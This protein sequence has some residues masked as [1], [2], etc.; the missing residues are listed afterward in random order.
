MLCSV[1]CEVAVQCAGVVPGKRPGSHT[2]LPAGSGSPLLAAHLDC[3]S[4][5]QCC[6]HKCQTYLLA[7]AASRGSSCHL[8]RRVSD[9]A[10]HPG[11][12][13]GCQCCLGNKHGRP[14]HRTPAGG[15]TSRPRQCSCSTHS[16]TRPGTI[17]VPWGTGLLPEW[18]PRKGRL[19]LHT[20]IPLVQQ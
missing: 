5:P 4:L 17:Q 19:A 20:G 1:S 18:Q 6:P 12:C 13:G 2:D 15:G 3:P 7:G 9:S 10:C 8:C 11:L 14:C 16:S